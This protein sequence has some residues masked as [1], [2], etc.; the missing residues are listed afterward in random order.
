MNTLLQLGRSHLVIDDIKL[1]YHNDPFCWERVQHINKYPM[2][3]FENDVLLIGGGQGLVI[4]MLRVTKLLQAILLVAHDAPISGHRSAESMLE[5]VRRDYFWPKMSRSVKRYVKTCDLCQRNK[6]I[7]QK[8]LG[9][10]QSL[11]VPID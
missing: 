11:P 2:Y 10:L 5:K 3:L 7:N 9:L 1:N 8:T 6:A 4:Y